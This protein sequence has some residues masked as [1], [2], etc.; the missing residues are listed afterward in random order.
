MK[1]MILPGAL[2]GIIGG[3]LH[4]WLFAHAARRMGYRVAL[5][6]AEADCPAAQIANLAISAPREDVDAV[7]DLARNVAAVV[8]DVE[9]LSAEAAEVAAR[10]APLRPGLRVMPVAQHRAREKRYLQQLG[11]P[12]APFA[13]IDSLATLRGALTQ[14]GLPAVL[15][16]AQRGS[17]ARRQFTIQSPLQAAEAWK[18]LGWQPSILEPWLDIQQELAV[19]VARSPCGDMVTYGPILNT[20]RRGRCDSSR[21]PADLP[22]AVSER[23]IQLARFLSGR[24]KITGLLCV[25]MFLTGGGE[26]LVNRLVPR[27]H[28]SGYL[29]LHAHATSQY[30]QLVRA[31]CGLPLG[32]V[33][34][35]RPAATV[36]LL[37]ELWQDGEPDWAKAFKIPGTCLHLYAKRNPRPDERMGHLGASAGD[38]RRALVRA[39]TAREVLRKPR[40]TIWRPAAVSNGPRPA[41]LALPAAARA[42]SAAVA[43]PRAAAPTRRIA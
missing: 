3:G 27:A 11:L 35:L 37:G 2:L 41:S 15:K 40:S 34:Q 6:S 28:D 39:S 19:I 20:Y 1:T 21:A 8:V 9:D 42:D 32:S 33:E 43:G 25:E 38:S 13:D 12:V 16:V 18:A 36:G 24:L 23:A 22:K 5:L 30:E 26:L 10:R 17:A 7:A 14:L 31:T 29:T 4:S